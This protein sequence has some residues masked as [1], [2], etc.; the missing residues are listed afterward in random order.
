MMKIDKG[1]MSRIRRIEWQTGSKPV[2]ILESSP[3]PS[4]FRY[5]QEIG[6]KVVIL[7]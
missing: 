4:P 7:D 6:I 3:L 2:K 5:S 1:L